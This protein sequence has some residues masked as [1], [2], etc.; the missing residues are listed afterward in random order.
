M[1]ALKK[2]RPGSKPPVPCFCYILECSDGSYY[3]G[4]T[5]DLERRLLAHA[6][7]RGGRYTRSRLP[8]RLVHVET[9]PDR[10]AAMRREAEVKK[11]TRLEKEVLVRTKEK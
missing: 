4:W 7:R 2:R 9:L 3:T 1:D 6:S 10:S 5:T 8:V 11:M